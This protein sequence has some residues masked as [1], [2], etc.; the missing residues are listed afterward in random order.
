MRTPRRALAPGERATVDVAVRAPIPP[1]RYRFAF[2]LVAEQRAWFSE[3]GSPMLAQRR[4]RAAARRRA[5]CRVPAGVEPAPD[6][7]ERVRAAH[8]EGYGVVAGAIEWP[9]GLL[10]PPPARARAVRAR[11]RAGS[12]A[13]RAAACPSVLDGVELE[14]LDDVAGLPGVRG[15]AR[16]AV[17]LRRPD[18]PAACGR[19][20]SLRARPR[21]GRRRGAKTSAP[22]TSATTAATAR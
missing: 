4:R 16:R 7:Q 21:A 15:P 8:A 1:G 13:S 19:K 14:R 9:G 17:A 22:R 2:D 20:R 12:R 10:P 11:A 6:G 18:R 5:E 3:L